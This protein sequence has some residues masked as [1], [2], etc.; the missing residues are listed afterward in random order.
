MDLV[1]RILYVSDK[2]AIITHFE[3]KTNKKIYSAGQ[4]ASSVL[5]HLVS[6]FIVNFWC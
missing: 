6:V 2:S 3:N 1:P 5:N 4:L